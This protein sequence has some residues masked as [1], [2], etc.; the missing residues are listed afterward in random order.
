MTDSNAIARFLEKPE[1][2]VKHIRETGD[3]EAGFDYINTV[4]AVAQKL[5]STLDLVLPVMEEVYPQVKDKDYKDLSFEDACVKKTMLSH[6]TVMRHTRVGKML[7]EVPEP[8]RDSVA[9]LDTKS[10]NRLVPVIEEGYVPTEE[11]WDRIAGAFSYQD[12][13]EVVHEIKGTEPRKQWCRFYF[14][15]DG[16]VWA[17]TA[18]GTF[19]V[20]DAMNYENEEVQKVVEWVI[21]KAHRKL[22]ATKKP[23]E[24]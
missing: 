6:E 16:S 2:L 12:V 14:D 15:D 23:K 24:R 17:R 21:G 20:L 7:P 8:Y 10:K 13:A 5:D 4:Y 1:E 11:Q 3:I 18:D 9:K 19:K 22:E